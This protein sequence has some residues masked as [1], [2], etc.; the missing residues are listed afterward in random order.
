MYGQFGIYHEI[1]RVRAEIERRARDEDAS[2]VG[3]LTPESEESDPVSGPVD[4]RVR[5][6]FSGFAHLGHRG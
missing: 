3:L 1:V 6:S 4:R 5:H 2:T